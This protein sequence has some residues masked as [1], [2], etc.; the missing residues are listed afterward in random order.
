MLVVCTPPTAGLLVPRP[1]LPY[2]RLGSRPIAGTETRIYFVFFTRR[3]LRPLAERASRAR[4]TPSNTPVLRRV[5]VRRV[6]DAGMS[7]TKIG[8][9]LGITRQAATKR[10]SK[11]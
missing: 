6:L 1:L 10:Y 8:E 5:L 11:P 2:S 7:W 3:G 9:L 4:L